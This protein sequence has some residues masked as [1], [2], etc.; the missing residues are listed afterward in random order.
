[1]VSPTRVLPI[2]VL[3]TFACERSP[4]A[5]ILPDSVPTRLVEGGATAVFDVYYCGVEHPERTL[6]LY[7]PGTPRATPAPLVVHIH[8]GAW[9]VGDKREGTWFERIA[10]I[11]L[12]EGFTV[13]SVDYRLAPD[14]P[15]P[16]P[17]DDV[18]CAMEFLLRAAPVL[19]IDPARIG[20]FGTSA[21]AHLAAL[22]SLSAGRVPVAFVGLYGIYD[23]TGSDLSDP[24][25]L[26][27]ADVFGAPAGSGDPV[28]ERASPIRLA[29]GDDVPTL[30]VH[31]VDDSVV[32]VGQSV[33]L[34]AALRE[35]GAPAELILVERAEHQLIPTT[36]AID[37]SEEA[38]VTAIVE[39]LEAGLR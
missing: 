13:A 2:L 17:I 5:F 32:P 19:E 20:I 1:M 11:L 25:R 27:T 37:P 36:G 14:D 7:R 12:D 24:I 26:A 30:L 21:G 3:A 10:R 29:S 39:F 35:A 18:R 33:R 16:R 34:D 8:G 31:G 4:V 28:L 22:A 9:R 15:W 38:I 6:D 23:L